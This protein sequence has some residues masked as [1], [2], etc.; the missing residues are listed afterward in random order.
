MTEWSANDV[1]TINPGQSAIFSTPMV[2]GD[3]GDIKHMPSTG[4]FLVSGGPTP[5]RNCGCPINAYVPCYVS[6]GGNIAVATGGAADE[7][8]IAVALD[9]AAIPASEMVITPAAAEEYGNVS[10]AISVPIWAG[11]CQSVSIQNTSDQ[12]IFL[13]N[14]HIALDRSNRRI[15]TSC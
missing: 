5:R 12:P 8:S 9:G 2:P 6:F 11:C 4:P 7:I 1:Q 15:R 14:A 10:V 3:S 13:K